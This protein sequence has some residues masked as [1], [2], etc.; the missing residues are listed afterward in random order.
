M[1]LCII[2]YYHSG[3]SYTANALIM[4]NVLK[5][6]FIGLLFIMVGCHK[7]NTGDDIGGAMIL[8]LDE[9]REV[10]AGQTLQNRSYQITLEVEKI[11]DGRCPRQVVCVWEG[12]AQVHIKL[13][14]GKEIHQFILNTN[15]RPEFARD[16][17]IDQM[18]YWLKDVT[19]YPEVFEDYNNPNAK[20]LLLVTKA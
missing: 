15:T 13:T 4:G 1:Y 16:T 20:A 9:E 8:K 10:K 14:T 6:G 7:S 11:E 12:N 17:I 5:I 18:H 3:I 2:F 19:P